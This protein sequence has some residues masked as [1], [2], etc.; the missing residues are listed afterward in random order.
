MHNIVSV[1]IVSWLKEFEVIATCLISEIKSRGEGRKAREVKGN[2]DQQ[3]EC[4]YKHP[5]NCIIFCRSIVYIPVEHD[6]CK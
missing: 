4:F 5:E 1:L 2:E 3:E 6:I